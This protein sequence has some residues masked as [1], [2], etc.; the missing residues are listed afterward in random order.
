MGESWSCLLEVLEGLVVLELSSGGLEGPG[1][2][3]GGSLGA[4]GRVLGALGP[5]A[6]QSSSGASRNQPGTTPEPPKKV[7]SWRP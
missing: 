6:S 3:L 5:N 4:L 2:I 1:R 7:A